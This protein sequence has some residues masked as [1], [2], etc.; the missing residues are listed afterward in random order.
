MKRRRKLARFTDFKPMQKE[1]Q[2]LR[3]LVTTIDGLFDLGQGHIA[4][5]IEL[6]FQLWQKIKH[7]HG[8]SEVGK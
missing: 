1:L 6:P 8:Q 3:D 7:T 2:M 4:G 5:Q